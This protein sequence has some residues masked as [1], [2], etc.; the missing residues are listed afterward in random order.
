MLQYSLKIAIFRY[1]LLS[2]SVPQI[3]I[4]DFYVTIKNYREQKITIFVIR[5]IA[6]TLL[7]NIKV[8]WGIFI[9][10]KNFSALNIVTKKYKNFLKEVFVC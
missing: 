7:L 3:S 9:C 2:F 6:N 4:K 1:V 8:L 10:L 5:T